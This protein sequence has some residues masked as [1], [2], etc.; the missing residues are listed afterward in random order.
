MRCA[1]CKWKY[2]DAI[3]SQ[4]FVNGKYTQ[5][6]CGICAL[7]RTNEVLVQELRRKRF[8]GQ[9]A[10]S[11]RVSAVQWRKTHPNDAPIKD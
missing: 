11:N 6:I 4:M 1:D 7:E 10:E 3:L 9:M 8:Q 2:P 5:P